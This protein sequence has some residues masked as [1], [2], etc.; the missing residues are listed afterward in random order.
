MPN[1]LASQSSP[2]LRQHADNPVD[3]Y[4][5]GDEAF[6]KARAE[7]K[8]IFLSVGYSTCHWCH[9]MAHESFEN[10][11]IAK[12][13][14]DNF[15]PIK[16]D[17]EERPDVD[18]V[19][20][21]FVQATTGSGGWPMSVW[22]TPELEPFY[23][24][25]YFP[26]VAQWGRPGFVDVL[27]EISRVWRSEPEKVRQSAAQVTR[28]ITRLADARG[29]GSRSLGGEDADR[30]LDDAV[31]EFA[32][33]FDGTHGGF[34]GAPKF[35]R[36]SELLFLLREAARLP[37]DGA[38]AGKHRD[39]DAGAREMVVRTLHAMAAGGIHDHVGGGFH[40]YSV[41]AR[42]HVPHFEKMLYDQA[43][44]VLAYLEA[45]QSTGDEGFAR[46]A[47]STLEYVARDL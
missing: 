26:S 30:M 7:S 35:P 14:N 37:S 20:M 5:W 42:W 29:G 34:G 31:S 46:V 17:R 11:A 10:E 27:H 22:L 6:E 43:Q 41:D 32:R 47:A 28:Q 1:R 38:A 12:V 16:V 19:Y 15:V 2:Y 8:P 40:R 33:A 45:F 3:W 25:T 13:L 36:P 23:G 4:P 18:R 21:L 9:V 24:G 39:A 44:L